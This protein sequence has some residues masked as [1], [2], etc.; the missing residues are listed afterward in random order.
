M[1]NGVSDIFGYFHGESVTIYE[2]STKDDYSGTDNFTA[3]KS[4][5]CNVRPIGGETE[6]K[7]FGF[8]HNAEYRLYHKN[9]A[10]IFPGRYAEI[11]GVKYLITHTER[12]TLG[13]CT[14]LR[15]EGQ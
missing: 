6:E 15:S 5:L 12:R 1:V 4:V 10:E 2:K 14:Y 11:D 13:A 3:V 9:D 7:E 8:S